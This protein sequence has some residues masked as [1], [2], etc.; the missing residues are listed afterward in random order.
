MQQDRTR[1][2]LFGF[3]LGDGTKWQGAGPV[4]LT[5][6]R[7]QHLAVV[8]DGTN[9]TVYLDGQQASQAPVQRTGRVIFDVAKA[10]IFTDYAGHDYFQMPIAAIN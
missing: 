7:W 10:A 1:T 8:C 5:A 6:N 3:G 9:A 2:N 4:Q